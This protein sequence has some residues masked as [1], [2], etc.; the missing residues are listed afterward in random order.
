MRIVE[1]VAK[2]KK[3]Y[4]EENRSLTG[5]FLARNSKLYHYFLEI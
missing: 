5:K 2:K 4:Y 1:A 3:E